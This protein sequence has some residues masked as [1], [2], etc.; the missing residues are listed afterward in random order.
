M[1]AAADKAHTFERRETLLAAPKGMCWSPRPPPMMHFM[2]PK[3]ATPHAGGAQQG[4]PLT[5]TICFHFS[6]RTQEFNNMITK[7]CF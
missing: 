5:F 2:R 7:Y 4:S 3:M 6:I 1:V